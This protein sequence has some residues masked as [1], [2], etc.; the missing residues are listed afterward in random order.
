M[1]TQIANT[2]NIGTSNIRHD[3][4]NVIKTDRYDILI[5]GDECKVTDRKT[6]ES[7]RFFG[8]PHIE[9]SDKDRLQFHQGNLTL[10]LEDG[11]KVTIVPTAPDA[12]GAAY[13]DKVIVT[14]GSKGI[15]VNGVHGT[16]SPRFGAIS[17][18]GRSIDRKYADGNVLHADENLADAYYY[19]TEGKKTQVSSNADGSERS[20][21]GIGGSA[22][23]RTVEESNSLKEDG[24]WGTLRS[25]EDSINDMMEQLEDPNL[26]DW[27]RQNL[28]M[29]VGEKRQAVQL[30]IQM[31]SEEKRAQYEASKTLIQ[32]LRV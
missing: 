6:G 11:T 26:P 8:D 32:N 16:G 29:K 18:D 25:M 9:T 23:N 22:D 14:N 10:D 2:R 3:A 1:S 30:L 24:V 17:N 7:M 4:G 27:K 5:K 12:N 28:V 31:L 19:D 21:D 20:V 15:E 13:I